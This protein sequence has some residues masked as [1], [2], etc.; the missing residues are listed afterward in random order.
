[1]S[2]LKREQEQDVSPVS[3][4]SNASQH[5]DFLQSLPTLAPLS[6]DRSHWL[7]SS[8]S[9]SSSVDRVG[10][11][12]VFDENGQPTKSCSWTHSS[13]LKR[14][15][16]KDGNAI[17]FNLKVTGCAPRV[18]ENLYV[19]VQLQFSEFQFSQDVVARCPFHTITDRVD[20]SF[21]HPEHVI[22]ADGIKNVQYISD[23]AKA[24]C[25]KFPQPQP[26]TDFGFAR[27]Q[28]MCRNSCPG[29]INRRSTD[30]I[31]ILSNSN[32][33]EIARFS[34]QIKIS[35]C[36]GRDR[37]K[38]EEKDKKA[39]EKRTVSGLTPALATTGLDPN[40][41]G[42]IAMDQGYSLRGYSLRWN[43]FNTVFQNTFSEIYASQELT[44]MSF[45]VEDNFIKCHK[46]VISAASPYFRQILVRLTE[47]NPVVVLDN[48]SYS[49][50]SALINFIY[51]GEIEVDHDLLKPVVDTGKRFRVVG[52]FESEHSISNNSADPPLCNDKV[53][54]TERTV[55]NLD[56]TTIASSDF[57][58]VIVEDERDPLSL[59]VEE[60]RQ[61]KAD[62]IM[63]IPEEEEVLV[64]SDE[65]VSNLSEVPD[66]VSGRIRSYDNRV[67]FVD[68]VTSSRNNGNPIEE[69]TPVSYPD[70]DLEIRNFS[71]D[72]E[73][74]P[75]P[76]R[77]LLADD[78]VTSVDKH[79]VV[80]FIL[81]DFIAFKRVQPCLSNRSVTKNDLVMLCKKLVTKYPCLCDRQKSGKATENGYAV[82]L[83]M[84]INRRGNI[85]RAIRAQRNIQ[86]SHTQIGG[87]DSK[88]LRLMSQQSGHENKQI[89]Q[90][91]NTLQSI[92][93]A[94]L[95]TNNC[96]L[97][98][99]FDHFEDIRSDI[100]NRI[101]VL[102]LKEKWPTLFITCELL[103]HAQK[104]LQFN[105][106]T[107]MKKLQHII[108]KMR[109]GSIV[110]SFTVLSVLHQLRVMVGD[111]EDCF[112]RI[113]DS[114]TFNPT[115]LP[116]TPTIAYFHEER[117]RD[118]L[119][120]YVERVIIAEEYDP[121][122]AV[123]VWFCSF[124]IFNIE[125]VKTKNLCSLLMSY[126]ALK[127][128]PLT[129]KVVATIATF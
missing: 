60:E 14:L 65:E 47:V 63:L 112:V 124:K 20:S 13:V 127:N 38:D 113:E 83:N 94:Q 128:I 62:N 45:F 40:S 74:F 41:D 42:S 9:Y 8:S 35:C 19:R 129:K 125:G 90:N 57:S 5:K 99:F 86:S 88:R 69:E 97:D 1:M 29:G 92:P 109:P 54:D 122:K 55:L 4:S 76:L 7:S 2:L 44:D 50:F 68:C 96:N 34:T 71:V 24:V 98:S 80:R 27:L 105:P 18:F 32:N 104:L 3:I 58:N 16:V 115:M 123:A 70:G 102:K 73:R 117:S 100:E 78:S 77:R 23:G 89:N 48:V 37:E 103:I 66:S 61:N 15:Y 46:I 10:F 106:G 25:F 87:P 51:C 6:V 30:L 101:P 91:S 31:F 111:I 33:V 49:V 93:S 81:D 114:E 12:V 67:T 59:D 85:S 108:E 72:L 53:P 22:R 95:K 36:P 110:N 43:K 120:V 52:L 26:G 121:I 118:R 39:Q 107:F 64:L 21:P 56:A 84:M 28:F 11:E 82:L 116:Q 17:P 79:T 126:A 119:C 75:I